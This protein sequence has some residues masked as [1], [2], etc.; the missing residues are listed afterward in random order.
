[1][2]FQVVGNFLLTVINAYIPVLR[3]RILG[4][5]YRMRTTGA[6]AQKSV[7]NGDISAFRGAE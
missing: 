7:R 4:L 5:S 2:Y 1:M 3:A 6:A